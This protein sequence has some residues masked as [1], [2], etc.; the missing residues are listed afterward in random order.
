M[1]GVKET[2]TKGEKKTKKTKAMEAERPN[3]STSSSKK[4][5]IDVIHFPSQ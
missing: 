5:D 3:M 2:K 1:N 4:V